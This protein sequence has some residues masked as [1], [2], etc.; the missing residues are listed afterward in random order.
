[1]HTVDRLRHFDRHA[2]RDGRLKVHR[3]HLPCNT[4]FIILMQNSSFLMQNSSFLMQKHTCLLRG[5]RNKPR[6]AVR[7][8]ER[9]DHLSCVKTHVRE[10][11][12]HTFRV[13]S[14]TVWIDHLLDLWKQQDIACFYM[15]I[16]VFQSDFIRFQ[17]QFIV[18]QAKNLHFQAK[19]RQT[20]FSL[21]V[22]T[23]VKLEA[24]GRD[25][26]VRNGLSQKRIICQGKNHSFSRD[27]S[28]FSI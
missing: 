21:Y 17:Q 22:N 3:H 2:A 25:Q 23:E 9:I 28:L 16:I 1:M 4:K 18:F 19:N 15:K 12:N 27:E 11:K 13:D 26:H 5:V 24:C 20:L 7:R 10:C 8:R 6:L 14:S